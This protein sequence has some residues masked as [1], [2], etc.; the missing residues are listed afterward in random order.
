MLISQEFYDQCDPSYQKAIDELEKQIVEI[1]TQ[2]DG[3]VLDEDDMDE[4][5][6]AEFAQQEQTVLLKFAEKYLMP[7]EYWKRCFE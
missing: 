6:I 1:R 5:E 2:D 7:K 4:T 3:T